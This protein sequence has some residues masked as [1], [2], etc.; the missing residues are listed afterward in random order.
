VVAL[1]HPAEKRNPCSLQREN[2]HAVFLAL[3]KKRALLSYFARAKTAT[4]G[5]GKKN[6]AQSRG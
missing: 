1:N 6:G 2:W 5:P 3:A 4:F